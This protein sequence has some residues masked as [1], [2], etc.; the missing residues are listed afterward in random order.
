V[1]NIADKAREALEKFEETQSPYR[2]RALEDRRRRALR[3]YRTAFG[4]LEDEAVGYGDREDF[5][6]EWKTPLIN[7]DEDTRL[8]YIGDRDRDQPPTFRGRSFFVEQKCAQC[9][10]WQP[11]ATIRT[12]VQLGKALGKEW[13]CKDCA[14]EEAA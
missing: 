13:E 2:E 12:L 6:Y 3:H 7:V 1:T 10:K 8:A 9:S 4:D 5:A 14:G 11:I